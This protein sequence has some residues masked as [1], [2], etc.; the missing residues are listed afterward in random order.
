MWCNNAMQCNKNIIVHYSLR[1]CVHWQNF[2]NVAQNTIK[3]T[4]SKSRSTYI[5]SELYV[6][7]FLTK[8]FPNASIWCHKDRHFIS[9]PQFWKRITFIF[10]RE[11]LNGKSSYSNC[12]RS[13]HSH[14]DIHIEMCLYYK[15]GSHHMMMR[16]CHM[17]HTA[18]V[19]L[20]YIYIII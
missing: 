16:M 6:S 17:G 9:A 11:Y 2:I 4:V 5:I 8:D 3:V 10:I 12:L 20:L 18:D 15:Q 1:N 14:L 13:V 19:Q 7:Y